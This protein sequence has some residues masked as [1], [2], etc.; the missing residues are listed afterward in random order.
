MRQTILDVLTKIRPDRVTALTDLLAEAEAY[1]AGEWP[2]LPFAALPRLHFASL[3]V[4]D[5]KPYDPYLVFEHNFDGT[6]DEHLAALYAVG[7]DGLHRIYEH[8]E[9]YAATG[10]G[11]KAAI[12]G[13]LRAHVLRPQAAYVG[14]TGR[15]AERINDEAALK[16]A[17]ERFLDD[18]LAELADRPPAE[19]R[20]EIQRFVTEGPDWA[21]AREVPPRITTA[22]R[23]ARWARLI[24]AGLVALVLGVALLPL[25]ML[26]VVVLRIKESTDPTAI[27]PPSK[28]QVDELLGREDRIVQ[29]HM[30][31]IS[32]V[33]PG[34]FRRWTLRAVLRATSLVGGVAY[35]GRLS[36][37]NTLHFAHWV[38]I[39]DG[40]R[41]LF[42]TNYDGSWENYLDD[43][44]D[45]AARGL[46]GIWSNTKDFPRTRFLVLGGAR[47]EPR[48]KAIARSTQ[49]FTNVWY[50]AYPALTVQAIDESSSIREDL[51]TALDEKAT[52]RWLWRF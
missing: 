8:C 24:G 10:P 21:W 1:D 20:A 32:V 19:I 3:V 33:K 18:N 27:P 28:E 44:I 36:G 42:L 38:M 46:T 47:D 13:Y 51:Y 5:Q 48:F 34:A 30:A 16:D 40:R 52:R 4:L 14:A 41:L 7:A 11:D 35:H 26:Y 12:L 45:R 17:I 15:T 9:G 22:E 6:F 31:S 49:A 37:L 50:S 29:N 39:D 43:F 23:A 2:A 25:V